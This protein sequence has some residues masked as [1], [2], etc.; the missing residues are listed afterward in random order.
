LG[1]VLRILLNVAL[2]KKK[3]EKEKKKGRTSCPVQGIF[4]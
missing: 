2:F 3:G 1:C 4:H